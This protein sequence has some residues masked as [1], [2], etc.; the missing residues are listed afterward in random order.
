[1]AGAWAGYSTPTPWVV[2][3]L[4]VPPFF[5]FGGLL[6]GTWLA[7]TNYLLVI[8]P[9]HDRPAYIAVTNAL[10]LTAVVLPM[11]GGLLQ[12]AIGSL[13]VFAI[14]AIPL[15][16]AVWVAYHMPDPSQVAEAG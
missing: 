13:A 4:F 12:Q 10:N 2:F 15:C 14:A 9:A 7:V 8:A 5:L 3:A 1:V 11:V 6:T 16:Y